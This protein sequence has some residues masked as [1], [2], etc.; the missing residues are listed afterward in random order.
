MLTF[1]ALA[2]RQSESEG[3]TLETSALG[4]LYGDQFTFGY[5]LRGYLFCRIPIPIDSGALIASSPPGDGVAF[6]DWIVN[7]DVFSLVL[8]SY[9]R[10]SKQGYIIYY[11]DCSGLE[12]LAILQNNCPLKNKNLK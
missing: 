1:R 10:I 4:F 12:D 6:T 7:Y 5:Q 9:F 2:P 11:A 3:L 8:S